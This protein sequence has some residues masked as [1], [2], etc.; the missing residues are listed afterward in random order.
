MVPVSKTFVTLQAN[1]CLSFRSGGQWIHAGRPLKEEEP[2]D[3]GGV[4]GFESLS[5]WPQSIQVEGG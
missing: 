1:C 3:G 5:T 4:R 2:G